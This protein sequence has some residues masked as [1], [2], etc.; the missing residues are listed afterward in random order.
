MLWRIVFVTTL[1][2]SSSFGIFLWAQQRG[3]DL[4]TSRTAAVNTLVIGQVFYLFNCRRLTAPVLSREGFLGNRYALRAVLLL[5]LLQLAITHLPFKQALF[6]TDDLDAQTWICVV[7]AGVAVLL[8]VE[9]EK[10]F[11]RRRIDS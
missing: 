4:E 7:L 2:V 5:I 1:L 10:H 9:A 6:G 8:A 11:W 3:L